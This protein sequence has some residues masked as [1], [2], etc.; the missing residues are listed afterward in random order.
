[1][2]D[3]IPVNHI[4]LS[5]V[6]SEFEQR[7]RE[8]EKKRKRERER[9]RENRKGDETRRNNE[10]DYFCRCNYSVV[11]SCVVDI[12][13]PGGEKGPG[14]RP[15]KSVSCYH[16]PVRCIFSFF[17][18]FIPFFSFLSLSLSLL[19]FFVLFALNKYPTQTRLYHA[20]TH[21]SV[22]RTRWEMNT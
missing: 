17:H 11:L 12:S 22:A 6:S 10:P 19:F 1:M 18:I 16:G 9:E 21:A 2:S 5:G 20:H 13:T 14:R 7:E 15:L 3:V 4:Y 8:K